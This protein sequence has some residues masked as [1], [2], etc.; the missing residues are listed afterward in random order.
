MPLHPAHLPSA[1]L[2]LPANF[3]LSIS[4]SPVWNSNNYS[5]DITS[6]HR[7]LTLLKR[8]TGIPW[9]TQCCWKVRSTSFGRDGLHGVR[10]SKTLC[11]H[12]H[13]QVREREEQGC[14]RRKPENEWN[15]LF[16]TRPA[17]SS[18]LTSVTLSILFHSLPLFDLSD[19]DLSLWV[20]LPPWIAMLS[21]MAYVLCSPCDIINTGRWCLSLSSIFCNE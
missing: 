14:R 9:L 13:I 7:L 21:V 15:V 6:C 11:P 1:S 12:G 8:C 19:C 4:D 18:R 20:W 10:S 2:L 3:S 16:I 5:S 17:P